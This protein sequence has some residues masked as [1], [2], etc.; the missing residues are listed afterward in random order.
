M[1]KRADE[2]RRKY[3]K[4]EEEILLALANYK[5]SMTLRLAEGNYQNEGIGLFDGLFVVNNKKIGICIFYSDEYYSSIFLRGLDKF[6]HKLAKE[7]K[8]KHLIRYFWCLMQNL[9]SRRN[10]GL[11]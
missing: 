2:T 3:K 11:K 9:H 4:Y 8:E 6:L 5:D 10:S 1:R 7:F